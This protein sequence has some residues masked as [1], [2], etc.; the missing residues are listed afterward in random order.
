[1]DSPNSV[2]LFAGAGGLALGVAKAGFR[3]LLVS[4]WDRESCDTLRRNATRV[5]DMAGWPVV[6]G[7]VRQLDYRP[8][9]DRVDLLA[10]G[11]PCQPFSLGGKHGGHDDTRNM[12]PEALR[13]VRE[14]RPKAVLFENV[15][16]LLRA[17]FRPYLDYVRAWLR[18][19]EVEP[20]EGESWE[21]HDERLRKSKGQGL[22]YDVHSQLV[23]SADYEVPQSRQRVL[24]VAFR[25]DLK[26]SWATPPRRTSEEALF[27]E[28]WISRR[29]WEDVG[30]PVPR[31]SPAIKER[32]LREGRPLFPPAA[33]RWRTVRDALKGLP[34]PRAGMDAPDVANHV[35]IQG[36][37]SYPGHTGSEL[38]QPAKTLKAGDHGVPGGE[39]MVRLGGSRVRYFTVR[40]AARLQTFPDEFVFGGS[41]SESMRQLG[42]AVPV[43][44]AETFARAIRD[45][46]AAAG[47]KRKPRVAAV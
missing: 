38:D 15:K 20:R 46:L 1:V 42:N 14:L 29:Y 31:P 30:Q 36:A 47:S 32:L 8:W 16:G 3:H 9:R 44:L 18:F 11:P 12:F 37:R 41:W 45:R 13:A 43:A 5:P 33:A 10:G 28:Q 40:E 2:E 17:S 34:A 25:S 39:N 26:V 19:P 27:H 22:E 4:E 23:D 7:D 35:L 21:Q 24:L 6:E